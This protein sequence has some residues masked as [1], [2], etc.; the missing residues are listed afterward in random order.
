MDWGGDLSESA[1]AVDDPLES[2]EELEWVVVDPD[3][4]AAGEDL[5]A[6]LS[7]VTFT[8]RFVDP[9]HRPLAGVTVKAWIFKTPHLAES[10]S[11]GA[12]TLNLPFTGDTE[13]PELYFRA[14]RTC[15][16]HHRERR[17]VAAGDTID[18]GEIVLEP[19][20]EVAG[21][22]LDRAGRPV[23]R[24]NVYYKGIRF[25]MDSDSC[26]VTRSDGSFRRWD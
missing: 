5:R 21:R 23:P 10:D 12:V 14:W 15:F 7:K 9:R 11:S 6:S 24:M 18:F 13:R 17:K 4:D 2:A 22:V 25:L 8:I 16:K 26:G 3:A 20:G 19:A 1:P